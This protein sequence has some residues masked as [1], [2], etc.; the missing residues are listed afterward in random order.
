MS[1]NETQNF[2]CKQ[3][4]VNLKLSFVHQALIDWKKE[5]LTHHIRN[6]I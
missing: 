5:K 2:L 6:Q 3:K 4:L 1:K